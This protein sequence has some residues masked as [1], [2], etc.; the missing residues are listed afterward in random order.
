MKG[1]T[2]RKVGAGL[3][4]MPFASGSASARAKARVVVVGGGIGG[5]TVAKY[6]AVS[7]AS[8]DVTLIEPK[9]RYTTG[10]FSN[11]YL[12]GLRS[13]VSLT[14]GYEALAERYGVSLVHESA[15]AIDP[16]TRRVHLSGGKEMPYDRLVVAPG[17]SFE[18][19][20]IEGYDYAATT[21]MPHAWSGSSQIQVLGAQLEAMDDGGLFVIA[22]PKEPYRCPSAPYE[23][24]SLTAYHFKQFKPRS[25][26]LILDSNDSFFEQDLFRDG[27]QRHYKDMI[28]WLP[29]KATGGIRG[30][31]PK[32][33][34]VRTAHESIKAGVANIIPRQ[35]AGALASS[36]GLVDK[37]G[38][39]PVDPQS[40]E[41]TLQP[42][43]YVVGDAAGA[44]AMPK[45]AFC[46]NSQAKACAFA[47]VADLTGSERTAPHLLEAGFTFLAGDDAMSH[48]VT[49]RSADRSIRV[50]DRFLGRVGED[51]DVR[52]RTVRK[53]NGW[54]GSF[55]Q[56]VLG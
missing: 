52:R 55:M 54:Y 8:L 37:S 1:W 47:I 31:D 15:T 33:R 26:I 11:L 3:F 50:A 45:T 13:L 19:S 36:A 16:V 9:T 22:V 32:L 35:V 30:V 38:W 4:A 24:A 49:F 40:F 42:G 41:S 56:D 14:H 51:A 12:A 29:G 53:A 23:R 48:V 34:L 44:G 2:R 28:E 20:G 6:L 39:C 18:Y 10:T 17:I 46:A 25:K 27:W 7:R 21:L 43:I 5:A